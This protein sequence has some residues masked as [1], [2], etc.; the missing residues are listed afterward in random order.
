VPYAFG[1]VLAK[2]PP[3][4]RLVAFNGRTFAT[5][6]LSGRDRWARLKPRLSLVGAAEIRC[7]TATPNRFRGRDA[8]ARQYFVF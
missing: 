6:L 2:A 3:P 7:K 1:L 5:S 4:A 8:S